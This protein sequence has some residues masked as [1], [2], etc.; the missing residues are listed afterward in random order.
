VNPCYR[1]SSDGF[2]LHET[3]A[4]YSQQV[5]LQASDLAQFGLR[6]PH[7]MP[8]DQ[9]LTI[10]GGG[11]L[12]F[13]EAGRLKYHVRNRIGTQTRQNQRLEYLWKTGAFNTKMSFSAMHL[14]AILHGETAFEAD[15]ADGGN[16]D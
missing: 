11:A 7:G 12:I 16:G 1:V 5:R 3:V 15:L 10:Y 2:L 4:T 8:A 6:K 13:D 14:D 9:D